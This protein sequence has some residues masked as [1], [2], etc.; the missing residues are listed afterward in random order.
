MYPRFFQF[1]HA[2]IPTYGVFTAIALIAALAA[3]MHFA[4]RL[5]LNPEKI[6][7]LG[8]LSILTVLIGSRLLLIAANFSI[9]RAHPFW[10]LGLTT[11]RSQWV[12]T[13]GVFLGTV[14][15]LL[16]VLAD[17]LPLLRVLDCAAPALA[18]ALC[19][20]AVGA[21]CAGLAY[22][23]GTALPWGIIYNS[24]IAALWYGTP[25]GI[26]LH[27]VQIY[28]AAA[29]LV[30]FLLL[31]W[32]LP[33]RR[34]NGELAGAWFF[35]YGLCSFFLEFYRGDTASRE[36]LG[37]AFTTTQIFAALAVFVGGVLW[38]QRSYTAED[39]TTPN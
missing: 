31:V 37:G 38:L 24:R 9:F 3:A 35:L 11:V 29:S 7:N 32:W 20:H 28:D 12:F 2:A 27:P 10:V 18:L 21:F 25:L 26:K 1:G 39:A 19:I 36:I 14:A 5:D 15:A 30:I 23:T 6:W 16:Y 22:G 34:Q 33:R 17:G 4:R 13:G 8:L